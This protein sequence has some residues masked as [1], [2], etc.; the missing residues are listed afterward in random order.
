MN[1]KN[2]DQLNVR[3]DSDLND[4]II[5]VSRR[6]KR[7][8]GKKIP[9]EVIITCLIKYLQSLQINWNDVNSEESL[10]KALEGNHEF[11]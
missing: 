7:T 11:Y 10:M 8:F 5:G 4:F 1:S 3:I 2:L 6:A 9:K